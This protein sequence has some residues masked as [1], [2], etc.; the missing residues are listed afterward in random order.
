MRMGE[1]EFWGAPPIDSYAQ[2]AFRVAGQVHQGHLLLLSGK[3]QSWKGTDDLSTILAA[4]A[5]FDVLFIGTGAQIAP[6]PEAA[7]REF[8]TADIHPEL[9]ATP[10]A[11]RSYN[12][13]LAEGRRVAAA[14]L[15]L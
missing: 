1:T 15:A 3:A 8:A 4:R 14:L 5:E 7:Q 10:Q 9:M 11:C 13:L 2:G 6:L 12:V